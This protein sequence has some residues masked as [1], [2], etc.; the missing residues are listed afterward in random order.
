MDTC[1]SAQDKYKAYLDYF[2]I[3]YENNQ[4]EID[5]YTVIEVSDHTC[6][7]NYVVIEGKE[8]PTEIVYDFCRIFFKLDSIL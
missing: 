5:E 1:L 8:Y 4:I 6:F 3:A 7:G 2:R